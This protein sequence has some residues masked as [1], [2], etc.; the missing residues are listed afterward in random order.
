MSSDPVFGFKRTQK[1]RLK[2]NLMGPFGKTTPYNQSIE[3]NKI[4][5]YGI[6]EW[7]YA[8]SKR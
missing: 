2:I 8:R 3:S 5:V 4:H 1:C 7:H 6:L